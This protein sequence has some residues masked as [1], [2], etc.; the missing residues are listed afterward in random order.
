MVYVYVGDG[1]WLT[2][3]HISM[4]VKAMNT[5]PLKLEKPT[6]AKERNNAVDANRPTAEAIVRAL[7]TN[8]LKGGELFNYYKNFPNPVTEKKV[9]AAE[10]KFQNLEY[11]YQVRN[12]PSK[13]KLHFL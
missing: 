13:S 9:Q 2:K 10:S 12:E 8:G 4:I 5:V 3:H 1:V 7:F 11:F 6:N